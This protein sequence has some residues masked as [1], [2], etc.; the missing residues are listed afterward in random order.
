MNGVPEPNTTWLS[1]TRHRTD[2]NSTTDTAREGRGFPARRQN[3]FRR[4]ITALFGSA[5]GRIVLSGLTAFVL[6]QAWLTIMA[7][8]YRGLRFPAESPKFASHTFV[9]PRTFSCALLSA[10]WPGIGN[11]RQHD[12]GPRCTADR[13]DSSR[14]ALLG[15]KGRAA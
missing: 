5:R 1:P 4:S 2:M 13:D 6:F 7:P 11:R 9:S 12:R 8:D 14:E 10:P 3:L 15:S